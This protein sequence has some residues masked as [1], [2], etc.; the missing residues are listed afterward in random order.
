MVSVA[1]GVHAHRIVEGNAI[2]SPLGNPNLP[3]HQE[4]E[5]RRTLIEKALNTLQKE[6]EDE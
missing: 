4:K 2:V 5:L 6:S 3:A 1:K